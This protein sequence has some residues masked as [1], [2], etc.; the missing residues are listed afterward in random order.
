MQHYD[1]P[2]RHSNGAVLLSQNDYGYRPPGVGPYS[3]GY[4][5]NHIRYRLNQQHVFNTTLCAL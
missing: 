3:V 4:E 5:E 1:S 2:Q